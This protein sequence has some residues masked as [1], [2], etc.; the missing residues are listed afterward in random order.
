MV[1]K[2]DF[3][4][5]DINVRSQLQVSKLLHVPNCDPIEID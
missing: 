4:I 2:I 5:L 3:V 1:T